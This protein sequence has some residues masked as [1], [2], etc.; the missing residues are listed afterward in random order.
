VRAGSS[1]GRAAGSDGGSSPLT[2]GTSSKKEQVGRVGEL[3][4]VSK[5]AADGPLEEG[6]LSNP[7][8]TGTAADELGILRIK[9]SNY[10][11]KT[12]SIQHLPGGIKP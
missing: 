3:R 12:Q 7:A 2:A 9:H 8:R 5:R 10:L 4:E 6:I 1:S 11:A